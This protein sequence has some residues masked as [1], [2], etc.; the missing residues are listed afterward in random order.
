MI[1][2]NLR[3]YLLQELEN[4]TDIDVI[5]HHHGG[6]TY[7][8][9]K[10]SRSFKPRSPKSTAPAIS[11]RVKD[12]YSLDR[13][14]T[15]HDYCREVDV[16]DLASNIRKDVLSIYAS[17]I[18]IDKYDKFLCHLDSVTQR[19][20]VSGHINVKVAFY[21]PKNPGDFLAFYKIYAANKFK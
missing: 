16:V 15:S 13:W 10:F 2:E 21:I 8:T 4:F 19:I 17:M 12:S 6:E 3:D 18:D 20:D 1:K 11:L 7:T 5:L 9:W 14:V